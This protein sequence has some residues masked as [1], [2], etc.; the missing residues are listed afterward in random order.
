MLT[1]ELIRKT[2]QQIGLLYRQTQEIDEINAQIKAA[3]FKY[4]DYFNEGIFQCNSVALF[5]YVKE[6]LFDF[7]FNPLVGSFVLFKVAKYTFYYLVSLV[8]FYHA[9]Y[10]QIV[11][12]RNFFVKLIHF[13]T[14]GDA[15]S[16]LILLQFL[17]L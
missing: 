15:W 14:V 6:V 1:T 5:D 17:F 16:L 3:K 12:I 10:L 9:S 7:S 2:R 8:R 13:F 4:R 11:R